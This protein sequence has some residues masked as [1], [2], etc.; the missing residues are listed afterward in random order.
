MR[1]AFLITIGFAEIILMFFM[2]KIRLSRTKDILEQRLRSVFGFGNMALCAQWLIAVMNNE[3]LIR[4]LYS[5]FF[6]AAAWSLYMFLE[7]CLAHTGNVK[8]KFMTALAV[9]FVTDSSSILLNTVTG[10]AFDLMVTTGTDGSLYFR[11]SAK[12]GLIAHFAI[13]YFIIIFGCVLL[14]RK[15]L[16]LPRPYSFRYSIP[17]ILIMAIVV[18]NAVMLAVSPLLPWE[19]LSYPTVT[20]GSYCLIKF[21]LPSRILEYSIKGVPDAVDAAVYMYDINE[22]CIYMNECAKEFF[23]EGSS[24]LLGLSGD[25]TIIIDWLAGRNLRDVEEGKYEYMHA[26]RMRKNG[27][28]EDNAPTE[29]RYYRIR[30]AKLYND[31]KRYI[32]CT[33]VIADISEAMERILQSEYNATHDS[34]TGLYNKDHFCEMAEKMLAEHEFERYILVCSDIADFKLVNEVFGK[35]TGDEILLGFAEYLRKSAQPGDVYGR[36]GGDRFAILMPKRRYHEQDFTMATNDILCKINKAAY[37]FVCYLG[38]YEIVE[39]VPVDIMCD[40]ALMAIHQIKRDHTVAVAYYDEEQHKK[41][42]FE[43]RLTGELPKAIEQGNIKAFIQPQVDR[44]GTIVGGECLVR[45]IHPEKGMIS[46]GAF[47]PVFEKNGLVTIVDRHIWRLACAKLREWHEAGRDD[48]Y[49]SVNISARDI[50]MLDIFMVFTDLVAEFDISPKNLKLEITE[51]AVVDDMQTTIGLI[52]NLQH[53]GFT[54]EMD[55]FG[56]AYSSLNMLKDIPVDVL[57]IDLAFLRKSENKQRGRDILDAVVH[58]ADKLKLETVVE[59]VEDQEQLDFMNSLG[60]QRYQGYY[61]ARPMSM[62]DFE[63]KLRT[64]LEK[65]G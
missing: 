54:V 44:D 62:E 11:Y 59:G 58:M 42:L 45:W 22:Q 48:L 3:L 53:F 9:I 37:S 65:K 6:V 63:E 5:V 39:S 14:A 57:K 20:L 61:F 55:D 10:H 40:R 41:T 7:F 27:K 26:D 30:F 16:A 33:L 12:A 8:S 29:K 23:G 32:G 2:V 64:G 21:Y 35:E 51:S 13:C 52:K 24:D 25:S 1:V 38:A 47:I 56:S 50:R 19:V 15:A 49:L 34:L 17:N 46:P 60:C 18:I 43:Q 28:T 36:I 31:K 4:I